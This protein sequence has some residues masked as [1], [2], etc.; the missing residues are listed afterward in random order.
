M[1][2]ELSQIVDGIRGGALAR[3]DESQD[4]ICYASATLRPTDH[5]VISMPA[6]SSARPRR[7]GGGHARYSWRRSVPAALADCEPVHRT[8]EWER[9]SSSLFPLEHP[10]GSLQHVAGR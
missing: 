3:V 4:Y 7:S 10:P 6:R 1:A 5:G 9:E 2:V 8:S